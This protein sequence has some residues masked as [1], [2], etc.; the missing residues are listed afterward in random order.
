MSML[1]VSS[2]SLDQLVSREKYLQSTFES[3]SGAELDTT[4]GNGSVVFFQQ[5]VQ[6]LFFI[7]VNKTSISSQF[8]TRGGNRNVAVISAVQKTK[9][10][11]EAIKKREELSKRIA[12]TK[13][14]LQSVSTLFY[15]SRKVF[16]LKIG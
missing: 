2:E 6:F 1:S 14:K 8:L 11:P 7:L 10:D 4:P 15:I 5:F 3:L 9:N 13:K 12:D 16:T